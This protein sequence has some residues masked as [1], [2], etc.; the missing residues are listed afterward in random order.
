[1]NSTTEAAWLLDVNALIALINPLHMHHDRMD[2]WFSENSF[3]G[4]ATCPIVENGA[5]RVLSQPSF[6]TGPYTP[7][8]AAGA[9]RALYGIRP[10]HHRFWSDEVSLIDN[11]L[12]SISQIVGPK[13]V[14]DAYL[15]GLAAKHNAKL[16]SFDRTLPWQAIRNGTAQLVETPLLQ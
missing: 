3:A 8:E 12:F 5:I 13:Q 2:R 11:S 6:A 1:L 7:A 14:T 15:L 16:V 4:W 10:S 9:L